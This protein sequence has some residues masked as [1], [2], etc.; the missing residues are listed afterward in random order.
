MPT[1][2]E[3]MPAPSFGGELGKVLGTG[4]GQGVS[5]GLQN[6][7]AQFQAQKTNK[8]QGQALSEAIGKPELAPLFANLGPDFSK[9]L[10]QEFGA[11]NL[12]EN[13]SRIS[14]LNQDPQKAITQNQQIS[15]A[16]D[17]QNIQG[18][19]NQIS[20][21]QTET[22]KQSLQ[23]TGIMSD[24]EFQE[25]YRKAPSKQKPGLLNQRN[26]EKQLFEQKRL[27]GLKDTSKYRE[28]I[29]AESKAAHKSIQSKEN[30][31]K[32]IKKG[33]LDNPLV[34]GIA[35]FLPQGFRESILSN[36][37]LKYEAGLFDEFG[38][39]KGMFP[40][41]IRT[42]EINLLE[43]KLASLYKNDEAKMGILE[44]GIEAAK[45]SIIRA[46]YAAEVEREAPHLSKLAFQ[47]EVE[48][49][50]APELQELWD[51]IEDDLNNIADKHSD[52]VTVIDPSGK[53]FGTVSKKEANMLPA[54]YTT[55]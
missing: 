34:A 40:G 55:R 47:D 50:A 23:D 24:A 19:P 21:P 10:I 22:A 46:K 38:V 43:P 13:Y 54:G 48:K 29:A 18:Q 15:P 1:I 45:S 49:R 16:P 52:V 25:I 36:D 31:I 30:L 41:Q 27:A 6:Q 51:K 32:L 7:L 53:V 35:K 44:A 33:N 8:L 3:L 28:E 26:K 5:A 42:A 20:P 39:L 11:E 4:F 2:Q 12:A 17:I 9:L 14:G 37:S